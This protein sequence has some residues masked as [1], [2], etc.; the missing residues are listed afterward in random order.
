MVSQRGILNL[1]HTDA[2]RDAFTRRGNAMI[3][4]GADA[5]LLD[6]EQVR[7]MYPWLN[8]DNARFP[9]KGGLLQR[10]GGTVRHDAV[11][12]GYARGGR[13]ARRRP[14]P[15]L[16]SH[17]HAD[18]ERPH[19]GRGDQRAASSARRRSAWRWRGRRRR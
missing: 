12:W 16:R 13:P 17:R 18:R 2:Q 19:Q 8:F 1:I 5:E 10:R 4:N 14:D 9:I 7:A 6:R 11:A 3:L 15:E